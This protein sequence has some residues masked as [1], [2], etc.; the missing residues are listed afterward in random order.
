MRPIGFSTGALA[1]GDF[2]CALAIL[3]SK[4]EVDAVELSA[5]R[6]QE[7]IPLIEALPSLDLQHF[8]HVSF[9]APSSMSGDFEVV[10]TKRLEE[11]ASRN[12]LI[13]V[14]PDVITKPDL[15]KC[16]GERL[17]V[18]NMDKR[19]PIGQTADQLQ[20][21]FDKLPSSSFCF[22][23]GHARQVDPTMTE[24]FMILRRFRL[25]LRQ[26]HVSEVNSDSRH[27][28]LTLEASLAFRRLASV[29]PQDVPAIIES[30]VPKP[31]IDR[32]VRLVRD[33]FDSGTSNATLTMG[34]SIPNPVGTTA[35]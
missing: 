12:W 5:L 9:H 14:H 34:T 4:S 11:V 2:R 31:D 3:R 33:L 26:L 25:R 28:E 20:E 30:R 15:W 19:K 35:T 13:V 1:L 22:D 23:V 32:E 6:E 17:C 27:G 29:I 24:A 10:A 21:V 8:R 18:E 7:L 16:L